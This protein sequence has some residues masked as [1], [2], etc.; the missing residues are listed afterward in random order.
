MTYTVRAEENL[1]YKD[2]FPI[3]GYPFSQGINTAAV[4]ITIGTLGICYL[5]KHLN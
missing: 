4:R 5:H 3:S 1:P 2:I